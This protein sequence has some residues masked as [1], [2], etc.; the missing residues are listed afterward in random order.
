MRC[1]RLSL[2]VVLVAAPVFAASNGI[3]TVNQPLVPS[4]VRPGRA[5]FTLTVNGSAFVPGA[6]V[7]WNGAPLATR[8][9]NRSRLRATVPSANVANP[10]TVAVTVIN[11]APGGGTSSAVFFTV[12]APTASLTF[13]TSVVGVGLS[14]AGLVAG[15]FNNDG[16]T[17]LVVFNRKQPDSQCYVNF[18]GVGTIQ[19]L[20]GNGSGGFSTSSTACLQD[21]P[22]MAGQPYLVAEDFNGDGN[23]DIGANWF[24]E[25]GGGIE[26]FLGDGA[27]A[28]APHGNIEAFDNVGQPILGDFNKDG[29]LD[30]VF[31]C[32]V[33]DFPSIEV[34]FGDGAGNFTFGSDLG[35]LGEPNGDPLVAG[36]FNG[37]GILDLAMGQDAPNGSAVTILLGKPGGGFVKAATQPTTT[38]VSPTWITT[39]DF[40]GDGILDLA[41]ADSGSTALTVLLG[42]GDGTFTQKTGQPDA[43]QTTAFI[44]TADLNGDGKLDLVLV[45]SANAALIYLGNGDGTF[46]TALET[47]TGSGAAQLAIGDFNG[48]GRLDLAV[49]NSADN[50]ISVLIQSPAATVSPSRL[51]FG[52]VAVGTT[53]H[54]RRV[55]LENSGSAALQ[56]SSI[57]ASRDFDE[58]N[59][60]G[61]MLPTGQSCH[62]DV[63]FKPKAIGLRTGKITIT[64][65]AADSPQIIRLSGTGD[66]GTAD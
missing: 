57:I 50:T 55:V 61:A 34:W 18:N 4:N 63:V 25:G 7:N 1:L 31:Q 24:A 14:P 39:G 42:S 9:I 27:G 19:T 15:D 49:T 64:D 51:K 33:L 6:V 26:I 12:T 8:F 56:L 29:K 41:F 22:E 54:P 23:L 60:C 17:D 44:T 37:D 28:F 43:G 11:P 5:A 45:D 3:P 62:I 59:N 32:L 35:P 52:N 66:C 13:A 40:N 58:T 36:D 10:E 30:F 20:L 38:L 46:Q 16:K 21:D 48:D 2:A 65:N 53:S 47:A